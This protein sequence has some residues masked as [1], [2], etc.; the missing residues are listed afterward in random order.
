MSY[1]DCRNLI[2]SIV[3]FVFS[4]FFCSSTTPSATYGWSDRKDSNWATGTALSSRAISSPYHCSPYLCWPQ[5][6]PPPWPPI[7]QQMRRPSSLMRE[8]ALRGRQRERP[9]TRM[10]SIASVRYYYYSF[11]SGQ[12]LLFRDL[13]IQQI[14]W[15]FPVTERQHTFFSFSIVS[16]RLSSEA[17]D[18]S[19]NPGFDLLCVHLCEMLQKKKISSWLVHCDLHKLKCGCSLLILHSQH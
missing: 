18:L 11:L 14:K 7:S 6:C 2:N 8:P 4:F 17:F 16:C 12:I 3:L 9:V 5:N 13:S 1:N 10:P 15:Y 19:H